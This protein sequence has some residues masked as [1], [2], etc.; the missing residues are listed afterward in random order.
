MR[1][2]FT[3]LE[4][5]LAMALASLVSLGV[6]GVLSMVSRAD[7]TLESRSLRVRE[8]ATLHALLQEGFDSLVM[9]SDER[10]NDG[11][12]ALNEGEVLEDEP[13]DDIRPRI[14]LAFD[15]SDLAQIPI[16]RNTPQTLEITLRRGIAGFDAP[17]DLPF[18]PSLRRDAVRGVLEL[19]PEQGAWALWWRP[20]NELGE[21]FHVDYESRREASALRLAGG[22][23]ACRWVIFYR[24]QRL[25][26]F[27]AT[28]SGDLPAYIE[29]EL[30]TTSGQYANWIFELGWSSAAEV[31]QLDADP[32]GTNPAD[33]PTGTTGA[34]EVN[35]PPA[36]GRQGATPAREPPTRRRTGDPAGGSR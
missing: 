10:P 30:S 29:L 14:I 9:S 11:V 26:E 16:A 12:G 32:A 20:V 23:S 18:N 5:L 21:P 6:F 7:S 33:T 13:E 27:E 36:G 25:S 3:M 8:L 1:R 35:S 2:A 31:A 15:P 34:G 4:L 22:L 19:R 24:N 28:W 17:D